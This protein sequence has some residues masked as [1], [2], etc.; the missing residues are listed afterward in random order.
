MPDELARQLLLSRL[1]DAELNPLNSGLK[2]LLAHQSAFADKGRSLLRFLQPDN[3]LAPGPA[4]E[5]LSRC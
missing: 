2:N 3:M 5:R 1:G 4:V